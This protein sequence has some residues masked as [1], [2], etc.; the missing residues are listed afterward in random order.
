MTAV[1]KAFPLKENL[2]MK[3]GGVFSLIVTANVV[4]RSVIFVAMM[5]EAMHFSETCVVTRATRHDI[6]EDSIPQ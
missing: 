5:M 6:P 2:N 3:K 1:E 4:P